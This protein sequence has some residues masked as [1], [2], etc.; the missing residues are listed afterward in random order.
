VEEADGV[1]EAEGVEEEERRNR[2]MNEALPSFLRAMSSIY[3]QY[4]C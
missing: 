4:I 3:I 2:R 1:E